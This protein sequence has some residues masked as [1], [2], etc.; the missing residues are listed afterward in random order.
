M[1]TVLLVA[2][3]IILAGATALLIRQRRQS[4]LLSQRLDSIRAN[5]RRLDSAILEISTQLDLSETLR[6]ICQQAQEIS[7][8]SRCAIHLIETSQNF[9]RMPL[10]VGF[11]EDYIRLNQIYSTDLEERTSA[12]ATGRIMTVPDINRLPDPSFFIDSLA[13]EGVAS[14]ADI[15]LIHRGVVTGYLSLYFNNTGD[16]DEDLANI[17]T[18]FCEHSAA[19]LENAKQ[20]ARSETGLLRKAHQ[21]EILENVGRELA[22]A[23]HSGALFE[24]VLDQALEFTNSAWGGLYLYHPKNKTLQIKAGRGLAA[25]DK[26]AEIARDPRRESIESGEPVILDG[27]DPTSIGYFLSSGA[28][29][30]LSVPL[31]HNR[32]ALGVISLESPTENAF[33]ENDQ[34]FIGQIANQ[35]AVA[36]VNAQL[37]EETQRRLQAQ[38]A[39][40]QA[41]RQLVGNL[42][43]N[44]IVQ[45]VIESFHETIKSRASG[46]YLWDESQQA[47]RLAAVSGEHDEAVDHLPRV[48]NRRAWEESSAT[49]LGTGLLQL[50]TDISQGAS[51][52]TPFPGCQTLALP[53]SRGEELLGMILSY[54]PDSLALSDDDLQLPRAIAAQGAIAIKNAQLFVVVLEGRDRLEAVL[55]SVDEG[56]VMIDEEETVILA[57]EII[58]SMSGVTREEVLGKPFKDLPGS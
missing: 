20:F 28:R 18:A 16:I 26:R 34:L 1:S 55:N 39:L 46:A 50:P 21:L 48:V 11:S 47:Y 7:G 49:R 35:A 9:V 6:K 52:L 42:E 51:S 33:T 57:N 32:Q 40:Y 8:A 5:D 44:K 13:A 3:L 10:A 17:L 41:S 36:L 15:P 54:V 19:A 43:L 37:Y 22:G 25:P 24:M 31:L 29:S 38:T 45:N 56:I 12:L 27:R 23:S 58:L 4:S 2:I 30:H 53:L 14:Y